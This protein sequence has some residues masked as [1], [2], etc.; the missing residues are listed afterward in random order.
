[1]K[2]FFTTILI[3]AIIV[4]CSNTTTQKAMTKP[5]TQNL[6][7][8]Y[9]ASG[10]FWCVEAIYES[11]D[12]VTDVVSGYAGG[13]TK[14]PTYESSNT[15]STGHAESIKVMY[16]PYKISFADLVDVY[17]ASQDPTQVN[18]QGNDVGSQYRSI[19]FYQTQQEKQIIESKKTALAKKINAPIAA[20][21]QKFKQFW[22]AEEYHQ[23]YVK[24]H[25]NHPYVK[26]VSLPRLN[27]FKRNCPLN[28][29]Q[30]L[31]E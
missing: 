5:E 25:P 11:L 6:K 14:N 18:G 23:N 21:I 10:C 12:G 20:E 30:K 13:H 27:Q 24:L 9:F 7:T 19:L 29:K 15:G 8:A 4:S 17:F 16:N 22:E 26:G 2:P 31:K 3:F 28:L 1:M